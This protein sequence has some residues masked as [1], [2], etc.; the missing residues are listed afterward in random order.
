MELTSEQK[1]KVL[2]ALKREIEPRYPD[3][4]SCGER[5]LGEDGVERHALSCRYF[6]KDVLGS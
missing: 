1:Q 3:C 4:P 2:A 5:V 6:Q